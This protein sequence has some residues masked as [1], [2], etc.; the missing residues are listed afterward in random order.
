[1]VLQDG[2]AAWIGS[3]LHVA[4]ALAAC[5]LAAIEYFS[6][7]SGI[8]GTPGA[9]LVCGSSVA[10]LIAGL[11][12]PTL[13]GIHPKLHATFVVLSFAGVAGTALA[14]T[15]LMSPGLQALMAGC[16]VGLVVYLVAGHRSVR[17]P[18]R[19]EA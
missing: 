14:A 3:A 5:A 10:L 4:S 9:L 15:F 1:M 8:G 16:L 18:T 17:H 7:D 13:R 19:A 6:P 2:R 11:A 12:L